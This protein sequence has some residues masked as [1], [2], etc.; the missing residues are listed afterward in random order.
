MEA[1]LDW[2]LNP[3]PPALEASTLPLGY[4]GGGGGSHCFLK[5]VNLSLVRVGSM[6][7]FERDLT[8]KLKWFATCILSYLFICVSNLHIR[9]HNPHRKEK[10]NS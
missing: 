7:R 4:R 5:Q 8:I 3:G 6:N 9:L 2:G 10:G 1:V